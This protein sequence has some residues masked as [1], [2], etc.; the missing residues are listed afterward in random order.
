MWRAE[1]SAALAKLVHER[2]VRR[3]PISLSVAG[4]S[5]LA[6]ASI[7]LA[8]PLRHYAQ[9]LL[10]YR[11]ADLYH[12]IFWRLP[13]SALLAQSWPQW[14]WTLVVAISVFAALEARVGSALLSVC[15]FLS[16]CLPTIAVAII[17]GA[18]DRLQELQR[19]DF[20]TSCLVVGAVAALAWKARSAVLA[21]AL[22]VGLVADLQFHST[23]TITEHVSSAIVGVLVVAWVRMDSR[24]TRTRDLD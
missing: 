12:G 8:S 5:L 20:G 24:S 14:L 18:A 4:L 16:H 21:L 23:M 6:T 17:A 15:L 19:A 3:A 1:L 10:I 13:T 9:V 22:V 11:G 7:R 2:D